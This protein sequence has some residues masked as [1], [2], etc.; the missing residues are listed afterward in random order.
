MTDHFIKQNGL[1]LPDKELHL[2]KP[3]MVGFYLELGVWDR[4][5]KMISQ[6]RTRTRS[7]VKQ[8]LQILLG[9]FM[10]GNITVT[11][12]VGT[13]RTAGETSVMR[14]LSA[15]NDDTYGIVIGTDAT[16][17]D[18][19]DYQ[20]VAQI[21]HGAGAGQMIYQGSEIDLDVTVADPDCTFDTWRNYNNNSGASI[22]VKETGIYCLAA[23]FFF[24]I[25]RDVP[26]EVVVPD[27]GGCYV[28]YTP[29][30]TE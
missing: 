21:A 29:K 5:N 19:T 23:T 9:Q 15:V 26:A 27:G 25:V 12:T 16:A 22:T 1:W 20:L 17:V 6:I 8:F 18:I 7:P 2:P 14:I 3:V 4:N 11:D 28:K 10:A 24:G 13:G 30:I